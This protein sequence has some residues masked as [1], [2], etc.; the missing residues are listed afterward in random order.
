MVICDT[1]P[2]C[3]LILIDETGLLPQLFESVTIPVG[4]KDEL[5][6]EQNHDLI[7]AWIAAP[8]GWITIQQVPQLI[9]N[10]PAKLGRGEREAISLAV[11]LQ[12]SLIVLD[13][14]EARQ[15]ALSQGLTVTGLLGLL[16]RAGTEGLLDFPSTIGRLQQTSFRAAPVLIQQFLERYAQAM[17]Q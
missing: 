1:S 8:P 15:A 6:A 5:M 10:L 16:F 3:Y 14:W 12:A 13:D 11:S 2:I 4:V 17:E 7:Q 9:D